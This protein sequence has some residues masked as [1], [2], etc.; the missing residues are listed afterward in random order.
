MRLAGLRASTWPWAL[1]LVAIAGSALPMRSPRR[2]SVTAPTRANRSTGGC[3]H[4]LKDKTAEPRTQIDS[5]VKTQQIFGGSRGWKAPRVS[6]CRRRARLS[7]EPRRDPPGAYQVQALPHRYETF[8]RSD[9][10]VVKPRWIAYEDSSG[11]RPPATLFHAAEITIEAGKTAT[12]AI[13]P[14]KVIPAIRTRPRRSTSAT[15]GSAGA[16][17]E[18]LGPPHVSRRAHPA[19]GVSTRI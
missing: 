12:I 4:A 3:S 19:P 17:L 2:F 16:A 5:V 13:E 18:V 8:R 14:D 15:T 10:H 11:A 9:G 6:R 1:A 7:V